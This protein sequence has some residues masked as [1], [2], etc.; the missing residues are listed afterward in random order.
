MQT[1]I[2]EPK[3]DINASSGRAL[4]ATRRSILSKLS[5]RMKKGEFDAEDPPMIPTF[6]GNDGETILAS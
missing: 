2:R 5:A 1:Q 3:N 6:P 4:L